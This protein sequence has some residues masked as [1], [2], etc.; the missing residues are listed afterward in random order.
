MAIA[1]GDRGAPPFNGRCSQWPWLSWGG[2][3]AHPLTFGYRLT[4]AAALCRA[5]LHASGGGVSQGAP[6]ERGGEPHVLLH[7]ADSGQVGRE[8]RRERLGDRD[9]VRPRRPG[10][11]HLYARELGES[12]PSSRDPEQSVGLA[13]EVHRA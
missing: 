2:A 8:A 4:I 12:L 6:G 11:L 9:E 1:I 10:L 5:E 13:P 3:D 7:G